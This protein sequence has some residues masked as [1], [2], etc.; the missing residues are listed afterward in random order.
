MVVAAVGACIIALA[1]GTQILMLGVSVL[2]R[3]KRRDITGD[4]WNGRTL[5]WSVP[6][7]APLYNFAHIPEVTCR[8]EFWVMKERH[9]APITRPYEDIL[10]PKNSMLGL[11]IAFC[12]FVFGFATIWHMWWL[13]LPALLGIFATIIVRSFQDETEYILPAAHVEATERRL[14]RV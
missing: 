1:V 9:D 8:D 10:L 6:S 4:Y 14:A 2:E 12:A 13:L 7:P 11:V 5:E 3:A